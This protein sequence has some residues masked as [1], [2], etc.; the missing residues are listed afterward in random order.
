M[1]TYDYPCIFLSKK[2]WVNSEGKPFS[3]VSFYAEAGQ[4]DI[5]SGVYRCGQDEK[6]YQRVLKVKHSTEIKKFLEVETNV[7]PNSVVIAFNGKIK[8]KGKF[9]DSAVLIK[10]ASSKHIDEDGEED[11]DIEIGTGILRVSAHSNCIA[12]AN[13]DKVLKEVEL[14]KFRSASIIDG[15]HRVSGGNSAACNVFFPVTAFL[16]ITKEDQAFHFIVI[17][18]KSEKVST[19][20]IE[21][22]VPKVIYKNLQ[23]RL[24]S[25][26]IIGSEAD[27]IYS[28]DNSKDSPFKDSIMWGNKPG[29]TIKKSAIDK[30]IKYSKQLPIDAKDLLSETEL[31]KAIWNGIK[32][33]TDPFWQ[34]KIV[35]VNRLEY[36][37]Q[38]LIKGAGVLPAL[39][40]V[41]NAAWMANSIKLSSDPNIPN[42]KKVADSVYDYIRHLPNELFTCVWNKKSITNENSMQNL[43]RLMMDMIR[44]KKVLYKESGNDWFDEA[45]AL[46][47]KKT[48]RTKAKKR[49]TRSS[50]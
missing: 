25:A 40:L 45:K 50:R 18:R 16:G 37:N 19:D 4:M 46:K 29:R 47:K 42:E 9:Y 36:K 39:Q 21:A 34:S 41:V 17:N 44:T 43:Q 22:V 12:V 15:Q 48:K 28:L 24:V 35:K 13:K 6:G 2:G 33:H 14:N 20:V 10:K 8:D 7:I 30:I 32:K 31:I 5:W 27:I 3:M 1:K 49:N 11:S 26:S 38:F 23:D